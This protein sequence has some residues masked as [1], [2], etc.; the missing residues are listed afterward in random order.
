MQPTC[1]G[2]TLLPARPR[3]QPSCPTVFNLL[4]V[5]R[6]VCARR[7]WPHAG[8]LQAACLRLDPPGGLHG[9]HAPLGPPH[10]LPRSHPLPQTSLSH[11]PERI[12]RRCSSPPRPPS[13]PRCS[14]M[15]E[16]STVKFFIEKSEPQVLVCPAPPSLSLS[17]TAVAGDP[18]RRPAL[19]RASPE[20]TSSPLHSR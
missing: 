5:G 9:R 4:P 6:R 10:S 18:P 13:P 7:A 12:R 16:S 14:A 19:L 20:P 3:K 11:P 1:C 15:P 8:H 2:R 17:P